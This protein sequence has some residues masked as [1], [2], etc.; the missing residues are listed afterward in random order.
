MLGVSQRDLALTL[1]SIVIRWFGSGFLIKEGTKP[2]IVYIQI[3]CAEVRVLLDQTETSESD[4]R[5]GHMLPICLEILREIVNLL[6]NSSDDDAANLILL[7]S[8]RQALV[9]TIVALIAYLDDVY[10]NY[11]LQK[12]SDGAERAYRRLDN[13]NVILSLRVVADWIAEENDMPKK[14]L[15]ATLRCAVLLCSK[16]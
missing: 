3:V 11:E 4:D 6:V 10:A 2:W 14:E 9:G 15:D 12:I 13:H 5:T 1:S 8:T 7:S 16:G